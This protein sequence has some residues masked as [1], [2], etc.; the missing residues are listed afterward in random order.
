[1]LGIS[2]E[3]MKDAELTWKLDSSIFR[4]VCLG[5]IPA[6]RADPCIAYSFGYVIHFVVGNIKFCYVM[7]V[8]I[9]HSKAVSEESC[10]GNSNN[11]YIVYINQ[12]NVCIVCI[13]MW[14]CYY[15]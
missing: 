10:N 5:G 15:F 1:M 4:E 6:E 11:D 8:M 9:S 14:S 2:P 13:I 3:P 7:R 12:L